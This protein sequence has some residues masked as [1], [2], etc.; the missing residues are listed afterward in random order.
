M[1]EQP[2][3]GEIRE[4]LIAENRAQVRFDIGW[5]GEAGVVPHEAEAVAS[6]NQTP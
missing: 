4:H 6:K 3:C 5:A 1:D 2:R